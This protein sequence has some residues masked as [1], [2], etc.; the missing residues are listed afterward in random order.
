MRASEPLLVEHLDVAF[1][2]GTRR[3]V[4]DVTFEVPPGEA[5]GLVGESG[6]G[7][8]LTLRSILGL[9]PPGARASG[10]IRYGDRSL[11]G[12]SEFG[13]LLDKEVEP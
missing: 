4:R 6:S 12:H 7:K 9:L 3:V 10:S 5:F 2:R 8:S 13:D 1:A 11:L